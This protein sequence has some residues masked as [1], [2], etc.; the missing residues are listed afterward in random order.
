M[1]EK[2]Y[3]RITL[4]CK[5]IIGREAYVEYIMLV[6]QTSNFNQIAKR[7]VDK[8]FLGHNSRVLIKQLSECHE[9][10]N[11]YCNGI[12]TILAFIG[13]KMQLM[14]I[15]YLLHFSSFCTNAVGKSNII[16]Q[17]V[18]ELYKV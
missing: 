11:L 1:K 12:N 13:R 18:M 5:H 3:G 6:N 7:I 15:G 4:T 2:A 14:A 16:G 9:V 10:A 8:V 17:I